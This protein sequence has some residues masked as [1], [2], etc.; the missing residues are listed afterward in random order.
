MK[1][2]PRWSGLARILNRVQR[3][4]SG[5]PGWMVVVLGLLGLWFWRH[6]NLSGRPSGSFTVALLAGVLP[7]LRAGLELFCWGCWCSV[8][9]ISPG[10]TV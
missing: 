10:F 8:W 5:R 1:L 6:P 2:N 7:A 4:L 9:F 3:W